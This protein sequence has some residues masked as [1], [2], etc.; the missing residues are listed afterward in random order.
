MIID[1]LIDLDR[2]AGAGNRKICSRKGYFEMDRG[3]YA[4]EESRECGG[5]V[6]GAETR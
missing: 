2:D 5:D 4:G 1:I 3:I 6:P